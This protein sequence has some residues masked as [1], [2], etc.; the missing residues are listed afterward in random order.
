M[1]VQ[2]R[3]NKDRQLGLCYRCLG[4]NH[5]GSLCGID[6]CQ[7][8][9]N[10]SQHGDRCVSESPIREPERNLPLV[11]GQSDST[12]Q[13]SGT[14]GERKTFPEHSLTTVPVVVRSG[15]EE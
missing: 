13:S 9:H 11:M 7:K 15:S 6:G 5:K 1:D 12:A 2:S 8:T 4:R 10:Q 14:E 3:W